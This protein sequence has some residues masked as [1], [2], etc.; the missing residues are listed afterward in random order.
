[1]PLGLPKRS[2]DFSLATKIETLPFEN[3]DYAKAWEQ[4]SSTLTKLDSLIT[5]LNH[6]VDGATSGGAQAG[7]F[8]E[9]LDDQ[10]DQLLDKAF[11][12]GLI[13]IGVFFAGVLICLIT[14]KLLFRGK[15]STR[16]GT[17]AQP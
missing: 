5:G 2:C 9:M 15:E 8:A 12:R 14:A 7:Q 4:T 13:L 1:M 17:T 16:D 3:K 10:A 6:L 11:Q